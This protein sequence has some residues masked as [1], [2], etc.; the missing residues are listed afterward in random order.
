MSFRQ[1]VLD[2]AQT[3]Y[4]T[5]SEHL[6]KTY[7]TYEVLRHDTAPGEKKAKWYGIIMDVRAS[8]LG[9]PGDDYVDILDVKLEPETVDFLRNVKGYFPA[10]H[11]N[12]QNWIT[13]LLD[14][15]VPM[16]NIKQQLDESYAITASAKE[17]KKTKTS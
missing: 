17:K 2:Y 15:S 9:L 11:M 7:P 5:T 16:E 4:G 1:E 8:A 12:K 3:E 13:I 10:Y 6:W 14:G